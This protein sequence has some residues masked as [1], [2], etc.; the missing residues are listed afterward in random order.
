MLWWW[1][2]LNPG[3]LG[4]SQPCLLTY[5]SAHMEAYAE[6]NGL[7]EIMATKSVNVLL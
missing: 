4:R 6:T 3:P 5:L 2:E 7:S 1:Q